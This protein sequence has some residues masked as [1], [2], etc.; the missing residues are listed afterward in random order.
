VLARLP[1]CRRPGAAPSRTADDDIAEI[2][3]HF[4]IDAAALLRIVEEAAGCPNSALPSSNS[5]AS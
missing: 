2:A 5:S 3:R 1:L 4:G